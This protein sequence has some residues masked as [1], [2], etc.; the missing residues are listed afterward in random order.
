MGNAKG[1][2]HI[3]SQH[4]DVGFR[5]TVNIDWLEGPGEQRSLPGHSLR[6]GYRVYPWRRLLGIVVSFILPGP[7][8]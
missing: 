6:L 7:L 2:C 4:I 3:L 5:S 8:Y 1:H